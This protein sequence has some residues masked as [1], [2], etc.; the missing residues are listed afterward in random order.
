MP[1]PIVFDPSSA[2]APPVVRRLVA[3]D[4]VFGSG[5]V[6]S[7]HLGAAMVLSGH[8]ASGQIGH[9]QIS[10]GAVRS[11][12]I[13]DGAVVS[14][15]IASGQIGSGQLSSG[16]LVDDGSLAFPRLI[17]TRVPSVWGAAFPND[18]LTGGNGFGLL[19]T[20]NF[21]VTNGGLSGDAVGRYL[22]L[23]ASKSVA[24]TIEAGA[25]RKTQQ[26][27]WNPALIFRADTFFLAGSGA[28]TPL[29]YIGLTGIS[30]AT[31]VA[32]GDPNTMLAGFQ[33]DP[34][35]ASSGAS[36]ETTWA[37][38]HK[39]SGA[40]LSRISLGVGAS[41]GPYYFRIDKQASGIQF[42]ILSN[43]GTVLSGYF[44]SGNLPA[45]T[46]GLAQMIGTDFSGRINFRGMAA[47]HKFNAP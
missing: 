28:G 46:D 45:Q 8:L 39:A 12:H 40:A 3:S 4:T 37:V 29:G 42:D 23:I 7:G 30:A 10:S 38:V 43:S 6:Q 19:E 15:S 34:K 41:G 24:A 32:S 22:V 17:A 2:S 35:G 18:S 33:I 31:T 9:Q 25:T 47:V 11:G 20:T 1:S 26:L 16:A 27:R 14:G 13:G 21:V 5:A 36:G 44:A